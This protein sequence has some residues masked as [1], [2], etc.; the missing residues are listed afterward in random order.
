[1]NLNLWIDNAVNPVS[2]TRVLRRFQRAG[3]TLPVTQTAF[4][5]TREPCGHL[6]SS[7]VCHFSVPAEQR[8]FPQHFIYSVILRVTHDF[9]DK[10]KVTYKQ[11]QFTSLAR[12]KQGNILLLASFPWSHPLTQ[13]MLI[14]VESLSRLL[15]TGRGQGTTGAAGGDCE[16]PGAMARQQ[17]VLQVGLHCP[18]TKHMLPHPQVR[19]RQEEV[20]T[21]SMCKASK[22]IG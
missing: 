19:W 15:E 1:M 10:L 12:A 16:P 13:Q 20:P 22:I 5:L 9:P 2:Q 14:W 17:Q 11:Q 18:V 6:S 8:I 3:T 7:S 21:L 4:L